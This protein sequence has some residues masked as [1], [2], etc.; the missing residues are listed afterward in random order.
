VALFR[1]LAIGSLAIEFGAPLVLAHRRLSQMGA[2][3]AFLMHWGIYAV[4][5]ILFRHQMSGII[6][7]SFFE[8]ERVLA[9]I[10]R[11]W[12]HRR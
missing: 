6:Y 8:A 2:V 3:N 5:R 12:E 7:A 10:T 9:W 1:L 4:M 11:R